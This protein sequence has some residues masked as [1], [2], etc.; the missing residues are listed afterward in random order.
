[1]GSDNC[2]SWSWVMI[3]FMLLSI[4]NV[5]VDG[6]STNFIVT[7]FGAVADGKTDSRQAF[8]DAWKSACQ[9]DGGVVS[10]PQGTFRV[11]G[12]AVFEGPCNGQTGFSVDGTVIASDDPTLDKDYWITFHKVDALTVSGYGV[13]DGN[14]ASSWSSCNGVKNCNPLPPVPPKTAPTLM[15]STP[16]P[17][18]S[19]GVNIFDSHIA[20]G[21]D[22]ISMGDGSRNV[23]ISGVWCGPGHGISIGSLGK[24]EGEEDVSGITVRGCTLTNTDNGL[25]IK[26]W[27]PSLS[28]TVVSDVTYTDINVNNVK[29][30]IIIDQ[31]YCPGGSCRHEEESSVAIKGVKYINIRGSSA[32][33]TGV[34][35]Q[36]SKSYP[37]QDIELR[38]L[39]LT[40]N[41]QPT[42]ASCSS[43]DGIF[44]GTDQVPS[45]CSSQYACF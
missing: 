28:S 32:T 15:E 14:G 11:S 13:F 36:C 22:C 1:M 21:D 17:S 25:R 41:G 8:Q 27:A 40:Y 18:R 16:P 45:Q 24:Y 35:M 7:D 5:D 20:T 3:V 38:G 33:E 43:A 23:N 44:Q 10:V 42:T 31:Y 2:V 19:N 6:Q 37:C 12:S 34:N 30:P 29:N 26:T 9:A 39:E 4:W